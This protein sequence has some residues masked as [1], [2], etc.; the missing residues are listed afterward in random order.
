[1]YEKC[2]KETGTMIKRKLYLAIVTTLLV[3]TTNVFAEEEKEDDKDKS[4]WTSSVEF[5]FIRAT[6]NTTSQTYVFKGDTVYEIDKWRH[7]GHLE[8][9]GQ[10]SDDDDGK[11]DVTAERYKA[12]AKSD[13]KFTE[14]DYV[15]GLV[16][17]DK[18]RFSGFEYENS[19]VVGYGRKV[20]KRD[21]MELDLEIGPGMKFV[22]VENGKKENDE[23]LRLAGKYWW[24]ITDSSK[25]TQEVSTE[26]NKDLTTTE[27]VTGVQAN[28]IDALALK[29]SYTVTNRSKVPKGNKKTDTTAGMTLIYKF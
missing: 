22:K 20:I 6:G 14:L 7:T 2:K 26:L 18:D 1:M 29:F 28:I 21:D 25:F 19:I 17:W 5:G 13:Y 8:A 9:F 16:K 3:T 11:N 24:D 27:S 15:F 23:I 12:S 10:Q 4:P